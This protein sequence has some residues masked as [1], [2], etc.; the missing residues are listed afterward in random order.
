[1][2]GNYHIKGRHLKVHKASF[3]GDGADFRPPIQGSIWWIVHSRDHVGDKASRIS[4]M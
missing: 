2:Q 4:K 3:E 1:M